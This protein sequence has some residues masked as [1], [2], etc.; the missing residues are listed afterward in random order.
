M[1]ACLA[2][3]CGTVLASAFAL[4]LGACSGSFFRSSAPA[5]STYLLSIKAAERSGAVA[6]PADLT[7][8]MPHVR[9]G[10]N[11]DRIAALYPD[12]RLDY[13]AAARW[14]GPLDEVVQDLALQVFHGRFRNVGTDTSAFNGGYWL[15]ID[16]VD[17]QAEYSG[18]AVDAA[19][20]AH[21]LL[22]ARVGNGGDR[23]V[24]GEFVAN[25]R[26]AAEANRLA[27]VV[28]AYEVA[29]QRALDEIVERST[30]T[31][32]RLPATPP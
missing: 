5:T 26:Q 29:A 18:S 30:Q 16:V 17:F 15:E 31:L 8:L 6:I 21:V 1:R 9:T 3:L 27:P 14:S 10:L 12:R 24:L 4:A 22:R 2:A 11:N 20:T 23:R 19:P 25:A 7:V 28:A 32:A 13:F